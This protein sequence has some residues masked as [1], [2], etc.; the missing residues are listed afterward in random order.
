MARAGASRHSRF[1]LL[2]R[3]R[4][5]IQHPTHLNSVTVRAEIYGIDPEWLA[6]GSAVWPSRQAKDP[7]VILFRQVFHLTDVSLPDLAMLDV[8]PSDL[9]LNG[10]VPFRGT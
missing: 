4:L 6:H 10:I 9:V 3:G 5:A 8:Q 2:T 7:I 1:N